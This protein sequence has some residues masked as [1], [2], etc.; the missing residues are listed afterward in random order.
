[1]KLS[2][3][4]KGFCFSLTLYQ[5]CRPGIDPNRSINQIS[6]L[7]SSGS[8]PYQSYKTLQVLKVSNIAEVMKANFALTPV[9]ININI[10]LTE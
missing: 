8:T 7:A 2:S 3:N 1:M 10:M 5:T 4:A 6:Y 9:I